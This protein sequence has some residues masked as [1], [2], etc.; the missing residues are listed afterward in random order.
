MR[1]SPHLE[2]DG[3][4]EDG[5]G[6]ALAIRD[7]FIKTKQTSTKSEPALIVRTPIA[8]PTQN[9]AR[10]PPSA[11]FKSNSIAGAVMYTNE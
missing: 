1:V 10:H 3:R 11:R 9:D 5:L 7:A 4:V 2:P 6:R 8:M